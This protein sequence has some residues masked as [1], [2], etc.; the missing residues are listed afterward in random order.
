MSESPE[1]WVRAALGDVCS[2]PQY[3]WTCRAARSGDVKYLRTTDISDGQIDWTRVPFCEEAPADVEKYRVYADDILVSRA[4]SVGVSHRVQDVPA[5]TVFASYLIRFNTLPGIHPRFVEW[6]LKSEEYWRSISDFTAGIAIPNVNASKLASLEL[7]VPPTEEQRRIVAQVEALLAKIRAS[8]QRLDKIPALLKRFR[9]SVLSAA[10]SGR[11]TADWRGGCEVIET[12]ATFVHEIQAERRQMHESRGLAAVAH[13]ERKPKPPK[14]NF[15]AA[16]DESV[17]GL[18]TGWC[19]AHIGDIAECL[20]HLRVPVNKDTRAARQGQIPYYGANGQVGWIDEFL[21]DED[22]VLVVEDETFIGR[23]KPFSYVIR[24][25]AWVN[26]HAHVLRPLGGMSV[27]YLNICLSHYDFTPLTSGTTGR[28]KLTQEG[29]ITA[30]VWIAPLREQQEIVRRVESMF[31]LADRLQARY[32]K[33]RTQVDKLTQSV[34]AKAFRGELV[35]TEA[36]LTRREGREYETAE[37]LL[38][39]IK[40][41]KSTGERPGHSRR[42][43]KTT[44]SRGDK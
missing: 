4:G 23:E 5:E 43:G 38:E 10:C 37:S 35:P 16:V 12:A 29:L 3:G 18:P 26:N 22:L 27:E 41:E 31:A 24:G 7:P 33:A 21:F 25:K 14:N 20:D 13:R 19:V 2:K 11:L 6:F 28:R 9:Q 32:E 8:Q 15:V 17:E 34:L 1:G 44:S 36:E 39:R 40:K 30:P 42:G